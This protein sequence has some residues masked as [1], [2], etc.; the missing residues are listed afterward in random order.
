MIGPASPSIASSEELGSLDQT[1]QVRAKI[2]ALADRLPLPDRLPA[3]QLGTFQRIDDPAQI[4]SLAKS[5]HN[6]LGEYLH[7]INEGTS[8][9][10]RS[11]EDD[12]PTAALLARANRLGWALVDIKGPK[13]ID[14]HP[15]TASRHHETFARAG[16]P[17][18]ADIEAIRSILWRSRF[19]RRR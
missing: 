2:A 17:Q 1:E 14:I 16:V 18:F 15:K 12:Q 3:R 4:R 19:S 5:W 7:E 6:C 8:L 11:T 10:Y 13:N 9:I